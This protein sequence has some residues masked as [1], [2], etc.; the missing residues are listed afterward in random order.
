MCIWMEGLEA[1]VEK[2]RQQTLLNVNITG[3]P[4]ITLNIGFCW[5]ELK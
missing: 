5:T 2:K 3:I 4:C 1:C